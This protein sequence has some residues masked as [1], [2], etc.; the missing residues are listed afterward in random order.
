MDSDPVQHHHLGAMGVCAGVCCQYAGILQC[1]WTAVDIV[2]LA[3]LL[4]VQ[5]LTY[6][7]L[8]VE[9]I[10]YL[11]ALRRQWCSVGLKGGDGKGAAGSAVQ[12]M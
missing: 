6:A 1:L 4:S 8:V 2:S 10:G 9:R 11:S 7:Y 3:L 12:D 5:C